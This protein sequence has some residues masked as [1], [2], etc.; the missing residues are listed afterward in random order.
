M[1]QPVVRRHTTQIP[2]EN[3]KPVKAKHRDQSVTGADKGIAFGPWVKKI[4]VLFN[5]F[6]TNHSPA[7]ATLQY[8]HSNTVRKFC[9]LCPDS[10]FE[11][12]LQNQNAIPI[13][14]RTVSFGLNSCH[15]FLAGFPQ[16]YPAL[17]SAQ[18]TF[19]NKVRRWLSKE[20]FCDITCPCSKVFSFSQR[21]LDSLQGLIRSGFPSPLW[22]Y[23][24]SLM[25]FQS[26]RAM[27][28]FLLVEPEDLCIC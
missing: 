5:R 15:R 14:A 4:L 11:M 3:R 18:S 9:W 17:T 19:M 13:N 1:F 25:L 20:K 26:G 10:T 8:C 21:S 22:L 16:I 12:C 2:G 28:T 6:F 24:P 27:F 23:I 7:C